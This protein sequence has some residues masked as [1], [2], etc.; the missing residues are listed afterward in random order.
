MVRSQW[1][2]SLGVLI[3][4]AW[5]LEVLLWISTPMSPIGFHSTRE[6][7]KV[8]FLI[9]HT[10][11]QLS[12]LWLNMWSSY[13]CWWHL[14][15]Y[16]LRC[17]RFLSQHPTLTNNNWRCFQLDAFKSSSPQSSYYWVFYHYWS[18]S[19]ALENHRSHFINAFQY[20]HHANSD[21]N[22]VVTFYSTL[23][24][25]LS[26]SLSMSHHI[27]SVSKSCFSSVRV[28]RRIRS[29]LDFNAAHTIAT[30]LIHSKLDYCNSLFLNLPQSSTQS[31]PTHSYFYSSSCV[32]NSKVFAHH[33]SSQISSMAQHWTDDSICGY[34][35]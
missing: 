4:L 22:L 7:L 8:L 30:F 11:H 6:F 13:L 20:N 16:I 25:S 2:G 3:I 32:H 15:I 27:S 26:L 5:L 12:Y 34:L 19:T 9:P 18:A 10:T 33:F 24:L 23:S 17:F 35:F 29:T 31:P 21:R 14:T 1:Q 28:L